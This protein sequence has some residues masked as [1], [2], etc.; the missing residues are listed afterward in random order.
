M[1]WYS[2][3][4]T[5][6]RIEARSRSAPGCGGG[7]GL[8]AMACTGI[9]YT[10]GHELRTVLTELTQTVRAVSDAD[11][12]AAGH[13]DGQVPRAVWCLTGAIGSRLAEASDTD[14][15][16]LSRALVVFPDLA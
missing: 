7:V 1:R 11:E 9:E 14:M 12:R 2:G 16:I 15:L 3:S 4:V 13:T 5:S 10:S 8:A 6:I